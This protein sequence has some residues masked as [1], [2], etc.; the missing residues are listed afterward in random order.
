MKIKKLVSCALLMML[1]GLFFTTCNTEDTGNQTDYGNQ[2]SLKFWAF[3]S[4]LDQQPRMLTATLNKNFIISFNTQQARLYKV[5]KGLVNFQGAVYDAKHGPQ[6]TSVG[7]AY[8][9]DTLQT[10]PYT[11]ELNNKATVLNYN[12]KGHRTVDDKLTLIYDFYN[13]GNTISC[14]I[15]ETLLCIKDEKGFNSFKR[16]WNVINQSP[17]EL[18]AYFHSNSIVVDKSN[19]DF[20]GDLEVTSEDEFEKSDRSFK[21]IN[22]ILKLDQNKSNVLIVPYPIAF[23]EDKNIIDPKL[24]KLDDLPIGGTLIGKHDC[25]TCHNSIKKTIGPSYKAIAERYEHN[26]GNIAMLANKIKTGGSGVWGEQ[27]MT[28]HPEVSDFDLKEMVKYIFTISEFKGTATKQQ[29]NFELTESVN[30]KE[31]NMIPGLVTR[32]FDIPSNTQKFPHN[33]ENRK[34]IQAGILSNFDNINGGDFKELDSNFALVS[35]GYLKVEETSKIAFRIW[36]DDGGLVYINDKLILDHDGLHGTSMKEVTLNLEAGYHPLKIKYFQ[37]QGGKFLSFNYKPINEKVWRVVPTSMLYHDQNERSQIGTLNLP[38]ANIIKIPGD[39]TSLTSVHPSFD[40]YDIRPNDFEFKV[41]G[42]DFLSDG[43]MVVSTWEEDGGIYVISNFK[44]NDPTNIQY[45]MIANGLAEPLGLKIVDDRIFVM[46]KQ[47]MTELVD[48]NNDE[49]ID[50]YRTI[51]DDWGVTAN[52]HEF[53]FG[54]AEKDGFLYAT[55]AT[56]I[57]P[58]G[59]GMPNQNQDRGSCIKVNIETGDYEIVANGLRTPNGI[60]IGYND[61]IFVT[62]NQGDWLPSSKLVHIQKNDW[63][64]SRAVDFEGTKDK[65]EKLPVVWLPQDEIGNSPSTP[66][67][68]NFGP[69]SNQM[70]HGEVTHGGIKRVFVEKVDEA[71]QGA[72]FRFVQG[73]DAGVNRLVY[74][75]SGDLY[76]GGIGNPGNWQQTGKAWFGLER[77]SYN[78]NS[79][80]EMLAVR[81]KSNGLEIEFTEPLRLGDGWDIKD[82]QIKQWYYV[83]DENYG[84]PKLDERKLNVKS[85][86]VSEDRTKVFLEIEGIKSGHVVYVRLLNHYV[87]EMNHSLWSTEAWY[88]MNNIPK[89]EPGFVSNK[90][91]ILTDNTLLESEVKDGWQLLFDGKSLDK[92]KGFNGKAIGD[93]WVVENGE[94]HFNPKLNGEGGDILTRDTFGNYELQ[95]EWKIGNCGNSGIFLH[96]QE[97]EKYCCTW[98][99]G[100]EMQILDNT[101]HPETKIETHRAGDLFGLIGTSVLSVNPAGTW[102]KIRIISNNGEIQFWLNG[103]QVVEFNMNTEEWKEKVKGSKFIDYPDFGLFTRGHIALQDHGDEVWFKNIKIK[104]F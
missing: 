45:K 32:I 40:L 88:T 43:R 96:V 47:E 55:L 63:F 104:T 18:N 76:V 59:A 85:A 12:Y 36:C 82:F 7:D 94:I 34:A 65:V 64:G 62:D 89:D 84:G 97:D 99:T 44:S 66:L 74:D 21:S 71:L 41:G 54:L 95:L 24:S 3:R 69:Y 86:H 102:N 23:H 33:V 52:F 87:S 2:K 39:G 15:E 29:T 98:Q 17:S 60:G 8:H 68:L 80:F 92:M 58:G 48:L 57:L 5:W 26:D 90:Q 20:S 35:I 31:E 42:M 22:Y 51:C 73:L 93:K 77:L 14:R 28:P 83:P 50:E 75:K 53:G 72:V 91:I 67:S 78:K 27:V 46:Q 101:C 100:P 81:A 56:G 61:D 6:P 11:F 79:T 49:I 30:V 37:G 103:H 70:I 25:K 9:I 38:M 1:L 4:V 10:I 13:K 16:E 19:L